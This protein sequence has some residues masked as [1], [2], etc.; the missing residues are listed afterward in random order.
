M[1]RMISMSS[2]M[3]FVILL[4]TAAYAGNVHFKHGSPS[5]IDGGL[6]LQASGALAGLGKTDISI[7]LSAKANV[8][9]TCTNP[10][11]QTQPP[12]QNPAPITV[13][14]SKAIPKSAIKN[15]TVSFTV[16]TNPP[17][18]PISGALDCPNSQWTED[19]ADLAFT[20]ATITVDQPG[21]VLTATCTFTPP[22]ADGPVPANTVS[23]Q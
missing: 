1:R 16:T 18:T 2:S 11:G 5:F 21:P 22:T 8:T 3:M 7:L 23:C 6:T 13:T 12:G 15:G 19:I 9:A 10:S 20:T 4:A 14:G 17:T